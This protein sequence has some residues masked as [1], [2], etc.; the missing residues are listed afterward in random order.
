MNLNFLAQRKVLFVDLIK[1]KLSDNCFLGQIYAS[2]EVTCP[3]ER[4]ERL[5][6][7]ESNGKLKQITERITSDLVETFGLPISLTVS[8][9]TVKIIK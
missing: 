8:T 5:V 7:G 3:N 1:L 9:R 6:C 2:V 4:I